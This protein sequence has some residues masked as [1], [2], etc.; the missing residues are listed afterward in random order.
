M[1]ALKKEQRY[2]VY[3]FNKPALTDVMVDE[4]GK[5]IFYFEPYE[6]DDGSWLEACNSD[7]FFDS[8]SEALQ[9]HLSLFPSDMDKVKK[10]LSHLYHNDDE[11]LK[12]YLPDRIYKAMELDRSCAEYSYTDIDIMF[13]AIR[14]NFNINGSSF[15]ASEVSHIRYLDNACVVVLKSGTEITTNSDLERRIIREAFGHNYSNR[16]YN[17]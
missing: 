12:E 7:M 13:N 3:G 14:G 17:K 16:V 1:E 11:K 4:N 10:Y 6:D 2:Y 8:E 5:V 9:Y 15:R